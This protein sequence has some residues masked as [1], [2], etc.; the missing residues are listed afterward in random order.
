MGWREG[1]WMGRGEVKMR[2]CDEVVRIGWRFL[3]HVGGL[4]SLTL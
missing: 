3:S 4:R 2:E 1:I